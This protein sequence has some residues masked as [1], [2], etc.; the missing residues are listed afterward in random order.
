MLSCPWTSIDT[1]PAGLEHQ[2][3]GTGVT[4]GN[5]HSVDVVCYTQPLRDGG[6]HALTTANIESYVSRV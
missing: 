3:L 6:A 2:A 4:P 1:Q 5:K